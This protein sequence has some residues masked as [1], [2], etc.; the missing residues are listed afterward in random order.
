M[1]QIE[2]CSIKSAKDGKRQEVDQLELQVD[3]GIVGSAFEGQEENL[4]VTLMEQEAQDRGKIHQ[5]KGFCI[6]RFKENLL[7]SN[8]DLTRLQVGDRLKTGESIL[9]ITVAGKK[10]YDNCPVFIKEGNC[11]LDKHAAFAKVV[12]SGIVH[13]GDA[14]KKIED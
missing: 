3:K 11:G 8:L 7:I 1:S 12:E 14:I 5:A 9:E 10:C 4:Q 13:K 2:K 6:T